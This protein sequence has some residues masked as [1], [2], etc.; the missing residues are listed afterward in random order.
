MEPLFS[1]RYHYIL[2]RY[3][4]SKHSGKERE[5]AIERDTDALRSHV[6]DEL[7]GASPYIIMYV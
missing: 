4:F 5:G 1:C 2:S 3:E 6:T 7:K